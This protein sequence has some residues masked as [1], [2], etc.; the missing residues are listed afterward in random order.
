[1]PS[2]FTAA[3]LDDPHTGYAALR[4]A[5]PIQ[6]TTTPDGAPVWLVTHYQDV[7]RLLA[8]DRLSLNKATA[9][10]VGDHGASM[11]PELDAHM[12]NADAPDHTRLR[13]LVSKAFT[14]RSIE[15]MRPV[16][17][18][19]VDELLAA[20][21]DRESVDL[22]AALAMPLA[23]SVI[24]DVLG[25]EEAD[26]ADF[27]Q[28]TNTLR[29]PAPDAAVASRQALKSMHAFLRDLIA[30]KRAGTPGDDLLSQMIA[31]RDEGDRLSEGELVAMAFLLLFAGYD[32]AANLL[33]TTL[34]A[35]L[36]HPPVLHD[37]RSGTV[38]LDQILDEALRWETPSMLASRRF[39]RE[40]IEFDGHVI[41]AGDRVW[42]SL[43]SANRDED[44]FAAASEFRPD[45]GGAGHL[46]F[47]HGLHYCL[48]AALARLEA[49]VAIEALVTR[50]PRLALARPP[51]ELEWAASYRSRGL[52]TLPVT[53]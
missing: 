15:A 45:R 27:R 11:P 28:W 36:T 25:I 39:A 32:N 53:W 42:L 17:V 50:L 41:A 23:L 16:V 6:R 30:G 8:D 21:E 24:C 5:A 46:G 35:L 47:G 33:G 13:R 10:T 48:G 9:S 3:L 2:L 34:L 31:A 12:L 7:R 19:R 38:P 26:R 44:Q 4:A 37:L 18:R 40:D 14:P 43:V 51:E 1:M 52:V 22:M 20:L 49:S 29:S